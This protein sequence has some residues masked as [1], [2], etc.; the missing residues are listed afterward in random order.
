VPER[1]QLPSGG[2][3][4]VEKQR[5]Q[6]TVCVIGDPEDGVHVWATHDE[7]VITAQANTIRLPIALLPPLRKALQYLATERRLKDAQRR[8]IYRR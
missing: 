2:Q 8:R 1:L 6:P 3:L 5:R 7:L 4:R